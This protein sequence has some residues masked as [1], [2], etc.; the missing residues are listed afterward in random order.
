MD[1]L[2]S[3][4]IPVYNE[5]KYIAQ[6]LFSVLN[7]DYRNIEVIIINDGSDDSSEKI[8]SSFNDSRIRYFREENKGIGYTR[9]KLLSLITGEYILF[10]DGDDILSDNFI[11]SL[12]RAAISYSGDIV[13]SSVVPFRRRIKRR[14]FNNEYIIYNGKEYATLMLKPFGEF[15]YTHSRLF[16][17]SLFL[18][19]SFREDKIFEDIFLIPSIALKA[20]RVVKVKRAIYNYRINKEGLSHSPFRLESIDEMD[21]YL[22][23]FELGLNNKMRKLSLYSG[24]FFLTKYYYYFWKVLLKRLGIKKYRDKY[25]PNAVRIW[26]YVMRN[27]L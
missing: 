5:E 17:Q 15:C 6:T 10:V 23:N 16:H 14:E 13:A 8:I 19:E 25:H 7:Q 24:I 12:Y 2:I 1:K 27:E 26:K 21:G 11:S 22:S 18:N 20:K 4:L 9:N 3:V